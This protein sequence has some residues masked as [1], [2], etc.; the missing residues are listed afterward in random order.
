MNRQQLLSRLGR[1]HAVLYSTGPLDR[2][3]A[4]NRPRLT[5]RFVRHDQVLVDDQPSWMARA[6]RQP[7][8]GA[9]TRRRLARRWRHALASDGQSPLVMW[10]SHPIYRPFVPHIAADYLVYHVYD[11]YHLQR[12]WSSELAAREE[13][14]I[15]HADLVV[16]SSPA[17]AEYLTGR[18]AQSPLVV[19]NGADYE[20][21]ALDPPAL[22]EPQDLA[23]IP[24]PRVGYTGA[25]NR[26][27]D[28]PLLLDLAIRQPGWQF[29]IVGALGNLDEVT[30]AAVD[31]LR[32][33]ANVHF[34]GFKDHRQ[35]PHY[36]GHMDANLLAY[37]LSADLWTQGIYPLK[38]HEYLAAGKPV[39]SADLPSVRPF[40]NVVD[41]VHAGDAWH[42]AI[43]EALGGRGV[44]SVESRRATARG[45]GWEARASALD[46]RL[47]QM[48]G[49]SD[50]AAIGSCA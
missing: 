20:A 8:F 48:V 41:I 33:Q 27:V 32:G 39:V 21:F 3:A 19:E 13:W 26:K 44:G 14:L 24:H 15:R 28:F 40:A 31:G 47:Q 17:L 45:N 42:A 29:V 7:L 12:S 2:A 22:R 10:V 4:L 46:R 34:L 37:R 9:L 5:P 23:S 18:G 43:A 38:L 49:A 6:L 1:R 11:L 30:A 50:P 36:V 16:C 25:L 35:L